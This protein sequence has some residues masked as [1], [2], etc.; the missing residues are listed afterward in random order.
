LAGRG[1][2]VLPG[3]GEA[4][5]LRL[6]RAVAEAMA[7][8]YHRGLVNLRGGNVSARLVLPDG[9]VFVYI[10]PSGGAKHR[11][12]PLEV[13]VMDLGGRVL[14]GRPSSE[15]RLHLEVYRR[16]PGAAAVA[17]AHNPAVVAADRL[18]LALDPGALGVEARYYLGGCVARVPELPPGTGELAEAAGEALRRCPAAVMAGHGA[19][20]VG[21]GPP[22]KAVVEAVDRLEALEDLARA[23]LA[24]A[25][26]RGRSPQLGAHSRK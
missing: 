6:R 5:G 1:V 7:L 23:V 9:T 3:R 18:G 15:Y 20:A 19:V 10:T 26:L 25:A 21:Q 4:V 2:S 8:L 22:E 13:A 12:D 17:H 24:E 16:V 14:W 11:V